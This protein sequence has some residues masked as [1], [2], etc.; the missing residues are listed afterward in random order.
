MFKGK[1]FLDIQSFD[2]LDF[3][4][5]FKINFTEVISST[6][7]EGNCCSFFF[8]IYIHYGINEHHLDY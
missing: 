8:I 7:F 2:C 6:L 5:V 3:F 4:L 1:F